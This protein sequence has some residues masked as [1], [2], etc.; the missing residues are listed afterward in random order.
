MGSSSVPSD[1]VGVIMKKSQTRMWKTLQGEPQFI[2]SVAET[3]N[4]LDKFA[5]SKVNFVILN[6]DLVGSTKLSMTLPLDRLTRLIQSFNQKMSL[7]VKDFGG[8]VL[9]YVGDAVLAFFVVVLVKNLKEKRH[10]LVLYTAQKHASGGTWG[11]KS[12]FESI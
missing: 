2:I 5:G 4:V 3:Q 1:D 6:V 9:K 8:F 11:N 7:I 10:V 12:N